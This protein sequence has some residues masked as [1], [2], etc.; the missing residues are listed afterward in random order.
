MF[1]KVITV[2]NVLSTAIGILIMGSNFQNLLVMVAMICLC[3]VLM[4]AILLFSLLNVLTIAAF[5]MTLPNLM[6]FICRKILCLKIV[7]IYK[8]HF[9]EINIENSVYNY[10]FDNLM[11]RKQEPRP[12]QKKNKKTDKTTKQNKK[13]K[14]KIKT[15][16]VLLVEKNNN[17]SV[18]YVTLALIW[19]NQ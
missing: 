18:I 11:K 3:C 7:D 6:Q 13:Q 10:H 19:G 2:K 9:R 5:F 4:L 17:N 8:T 12:P 1:L 14:T 15:K 16:N